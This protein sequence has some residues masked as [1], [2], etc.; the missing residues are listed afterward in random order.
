M[1]FILLNRAIPFMY[2]QCNRMFQTDLL[3]CSRQWRERLASNGPTQPAAWNCKI[4]R[5]EVSMGKAPSPWCRE[6]GSWQHFKLLQDL[7]Q[8]ARWRKL[9]PQ[10][11][12]MSAGTSPCVLSKWPWPLLLSRLLPFSPSCGCLLPVPPPKGATSH[13]AKRFKGICT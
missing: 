2:L 5:G 8:A 4:R 12:R 11:P 10:L 9:G 6:D 13:G 1:E 7:I 3:R